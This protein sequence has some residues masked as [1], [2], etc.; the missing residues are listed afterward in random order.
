MSR[1]ASVT[2]DWADGTYKF[3]LPYGQIAEL[4]EKTGCGPQ[5]LL[6]RII[7][8][9]WKV[10]DLRETIRLGLIGGGTEPI[11]ALRKQTKIKSRPF[12]FWSQPLVR[13]IRRMMEVYL[14]ARV[15]GEQGATP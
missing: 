11:A 10:D 3:R 4:Q 14:K 15:R 7:D 2:F 1:D 8:G 6:S 12:L 9:S 5:F 13:N